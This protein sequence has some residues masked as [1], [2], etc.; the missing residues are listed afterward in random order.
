MNI[1]PIAHAQIGVPTTFLPS[2]WQTLLNN[3]GIVCTPGPPVDCNFP[4]G[5]LI[6]TLLPNFLIL[7]GVIFFL[8]IL[9]GGFMLIS[10]AGKESS[11]QDKAKASAAITYGV[12][13]FLLVISSYFIL[14]IVTLITGI[15][16]IQPF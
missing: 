5:V 3:L 2:V 13:G 6:T 12:I 16:F 15:N 4:P 11:P 14:E 10:G 9:G 1:I 7:A 8:L